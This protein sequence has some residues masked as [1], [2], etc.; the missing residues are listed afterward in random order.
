MNRQDLKTIAEQAKSKHNQFKHKVC[1]CCGAGCI[2]SGSE[3]V[4]KKLPIKLKL[5]NNKN[6]TN[7]EIDGY[8]TI[9]YFNINNTKIQTI[10]TDFQFIRADIFKFNKNYFKDKTVKIKNSE[11]NKEL[12]LIINGNANTKLTNF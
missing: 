5:N 11:N 4:L 12:T 6:L 9:S 2:S 10:K 7:L 8:C 1:V 3:V